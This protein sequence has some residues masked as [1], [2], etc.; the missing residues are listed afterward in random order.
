LV[1]LRTNSKANLQAYNRRTNA[2]ANRKAE[3]SSNGKGKGGSE[4]DEDYEY[5]DIKEEGSS[6]SGQH[7]TPVSRDPSL[8]RFLFLLT[9]RQ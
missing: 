9:V 8:L 1:Q 2:K 4:E 6:I 3:G 7:P 5:E